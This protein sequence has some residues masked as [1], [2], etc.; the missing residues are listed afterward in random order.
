MKGIL[1]RDKVCSFHTTPLC[2][3]E[4][5]GNYIYLTTISLSTMVLQLEEILSVYGR[6]T[7]IFLGDKGNLA[8]ASYV[9]IEHAVNA[10]NILNERPC[11]LLNKRVLKV[12]FARLV[13][14]EE[15]MIMVGFLSFC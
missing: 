8:Y 6:V 11:E 2:E 12:G 14:E 5:S 7:H 1:N 10:V 13:S 9:E 4:V 15:Y 3:V